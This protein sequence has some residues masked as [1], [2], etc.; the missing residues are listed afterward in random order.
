MQQVRTSSDYKNAGDSDLVDSGGSGNMIEVREVYKWFPIKGGLFGRTVANVKAVDGV[1]LSIRA[2][3]TMGLVGESGSGKTTLG[4]AIMRLTDT[5]KG[6]IL[7]EGTDI[8]KFKGRRLKLYRRKMQM[9]FQ[10]PYA[11]LDPRQ[12]I[13]SALTEPMRIHHVVSGKDQANAAVEKLIETVGLSPD[14]LSRFP[15]EFSGGQRQRIAVARALAVNPQFMLLDEPT[16][17]LDVSVQ[18][19]I[20]NLLKKLQ[21]QYSLTYLFISHNLSVI[22]HMCDRVAVM[23]LGR[24]V[25][26]GGMQTIYEN[27]KHPYTYALLSSVPNPDPLKRKAGLVLE[28]D[29]PSPIDIPSGCRFRTRCPYA[30]SKCKEEF[31]PLVEIEPGHWIECHYDIDFKARREAERK[32]GSSV[33]EQPRPFATT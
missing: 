19:Q 3:E 18:A 14:H 10:D 4:R 32:L 7:F 1:S 33:Q 5:T 8:T 21:K 23:Y 22:R 2:G 25:E 16:S 31:P 20:L 28:G 30:T 17:S 24:I 26:I 11:S 13:R 9:V 29:V 12:S 6:K 27:P 15:H